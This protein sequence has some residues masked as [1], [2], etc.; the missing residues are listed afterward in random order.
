MLSRMVP[1]LEENGIPHPNQ[2]ACQPGQS[3]HNATFVVQE[4]VRKYI[5]EG[6]TVYQ[7]LYELEKEN[8]KVSMTLPRILLG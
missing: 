6:Y 7:V 5:K 3:S 1:I 8:I 4:V 2:T